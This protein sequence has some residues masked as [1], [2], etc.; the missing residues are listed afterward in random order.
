MHFGFQ[1]D[2]K[3]EIISR[4]FGSPPPRG[5]GERRSDTHLMPIIALSGQQWFSCFPL[6]TGADLHSYRRVYSLL[7]SGC[8]VSVFHGAVILCIVVI[9][10]KRS[11]NISWRQVSG[12]LRDA[13]RIPS[14]SSPGTSGMLSDM[15][16]GIPVWVNRNTQIE[17]VQVRNRVLFTTDFWKHCRKE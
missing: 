15:I 16:T 13:V 12:Y 7:L 3:M 11:Y 5:G 17:N 4:I 14:E 10:V 9:I 6:A 1:M 8:R 2:G